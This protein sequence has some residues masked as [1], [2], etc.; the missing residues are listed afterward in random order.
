MNII[1]YDRKTFKINEMY[2][3]V[4]EGDQIMHNKYDHWPISELEQTPNR[5]LGNE[6]ATDSRYI[7]TNE[8]KVKPNSRTNKQTHSPILCKTE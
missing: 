2:L 4:L 3:S 6:K 7:L 5:L 8:I 1:Y